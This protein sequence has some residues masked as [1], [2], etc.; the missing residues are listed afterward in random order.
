VRKFLSSKDGDTRLIGKSMINIVQSLNLQWRSLHV[1]GLHAKVEAAEKQVV[2]ACMSAGLLEFQLDVGKMARTLRRCEHFRDFFANAVGGQIVANTG[3]TPGLSKTQYGSDLDYAYKS[4][5]L[6]F[7]QDALASHRH[8]IKHCVNDAVHADYVARLSQLK[9]V[10]PEGS[11][12]LTIEPPR[13]QPPGA[14]VIVGAAAPADLSRPVA[15]L[16]RTSADIT[17]N[18]AQVA[19]AAER[20]GAAAER[21]EAAARAPE[22]AAR[23]DRMEAEIERRIQE[24]IGTM[25]GAMTTRLEAK[26]DAMQP[27]AAPAPPPPAPPPQ[28][29]DTSPIVQA[30]AHLT[31]TVQN[32]QPPAGLTAAEVQTLLTAAVDR[33]TGHINGNAGRMAS[34][35]SNIDRN[36]QAFLDQ[37]DANL[38]RWTV[39]LQQALNIGGMVA[40]IIEHASYIERSANMMERISGEM[41]TD[42]NNKLPQSLIRNFVN[43]PEIKALLAGRPAAPGEAVAGADLG[44]VTQGMEFLKRDIQQYTEEMRGNYR[45]QEASIGALRELVT[46]LA[47]DLR[48]MPAAAPAMPAA[49]PAMPAAAPVPGATRPA[50]AP[51]TVD[52]PVSYAQITPPRAMTSP[53]GNAANKRTRSVPD[54]DD[55]SAKDLAAIQQANR[56]P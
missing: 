51:P 40:P 38:N 7:L 48:A 27:P 5:A 29:I 45:V 14:P 54:N 6:L 16:T 34:A 3:R 4:R 36:L 39:D 12:E 32:M 55:E 35:P 56:I 33:I 22:L 44:P 24:S 49:A 17:R 46:Q 53:R 37:L 43:S 42:I 25:L 15:E 26:I 52:P 13:G 30:I 21:V 20:V 11:E 31:T 18:S 23:L 28:V 9:I 50:R 8:V 10:R 2:M 47:A 41:L 19:A 1:F